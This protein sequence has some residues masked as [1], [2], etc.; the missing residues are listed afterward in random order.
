MASRQPPTT[1]ATQA[2]AETKLR[3]A[4]ARMKAAND[5]RAAIVAVMSRLGG[6]PQE[7]RLAQ[8]EIKKVDRELHD[9]RRLLQDAQAAA[10]TT[11]VGSA[12]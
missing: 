1:D 9:A 2:E 7:R 11:K 6:T 3:E 5:R 12:R 8:S 10:Q 4:L